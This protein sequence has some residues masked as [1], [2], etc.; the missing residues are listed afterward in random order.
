MTD[1]RI[2]G[3]EGRMSFFKAYGNWILVAITAGVLA[4]PVPALAWGPDGHRI[5]ASLAE[6]QLDDSTRSEL[7]RL[8]AVSGDSTLAD[9]SNWADDVRKDPAQKELSRQT[10]RM[11]FVNFND[12]NCEFIAD[13]ICKNGQ[14]AV[15]AIGH[16]AGILGN[17]QLADTER[18][19]A[20]RFLVRGPRLPAASS[21]ARYRPR[22]GRNPFQVQINGKGS[23][24]HSVWDS[25]IIG[26]RQIGWHEYV[27]LLSRK[28]ALAAD[29]D[30]STWAQQSCLITRDDVYPR[31]RTITPA[32]LD[33]HLDTVDVQLQRA[34]SRLASLL[35]RPL[36]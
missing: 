8:L 28:P 30:A 4:L 24:L 5:V 27:K 20:L 19:Q 7:T 1:T 6:V 10:S 14:C 34:S 22:R 16:Y 35:N 23:N 29:G 13:S 31:S 12:A 17:H 33:G 26:S 2:A 15:A 11:H 32:Y 25:K 9:V 18:A 21:L 36:E 3:Y